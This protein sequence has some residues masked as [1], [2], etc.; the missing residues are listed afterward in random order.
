MDTVE[1]AS[2]LADN[3]D[4]YEPKASS[5]SLK[6]NPQLP[7]VS[8]SPYG[9]HALPSTL[10]QAPDS[11]RQF[12]KQG[13]AGQ[14]RFF[15]TI[16]IAANQSAASSQNQAQSYARWQASGLTLDVIADSPTYAKVPIEQFDAQGNLIVVN[17]QGPWSSTVTYSSGQEVSF[18]GNVWVALSDNTGSTP[19]IGNPFWEL[20]GP[21]TLD[22]VADGAT[23]GRVNNGAL[24]SGGNIDFAG[25]AW[26]NKELDNL[27]DGST[28]AK[29]LGGALTS[30][31]IDFTGSAFL[32]K[33]IDNVSDGVNFARI[34]SHLTW[35]NTSRTPHASAVSVLN[36]D[37]WF[38]FEGNT[39][40]WLFDIGTFPTNLTII[41][42]G[43]YGISQ[44]SLVNGDSLIGGFLTGTG[45]YAF[46]GTHGYSNGSYA[47]SLWAY[48]SGLLPA[49]RS[50][51]FSLANTN[52]STTP[53]VW[54]RGI[55]VDP[56]GMVSAEIA[57]T[58][59]TVAVSSPALN[60]IVPHHIFVNVDGVNLTLWIDGQL[61]GSTTASGT[62][63]NLTWLLLGGHYTGSSWLF[64][65]C[66]LQHV[67][68]W[69]ST[70]L[71]SGQITA[72]Y[73]A[74]S[75][76]AQNL[77][78]LRDGN[79][80][81]RVTGVSGNRT[82]SSSYNTGSISSN[83]TASTGAGSITFAPG[84]PTNIVSLTLS[85]SAQN[86]VL[87]SGLYQCF[88]SSAIGGGT[89]TVNLVVNGTV[90]ASY[91]INTVTLAGGQTFQFTIPAT[92]WAGSLAGATVTL[93]AETTNTTLSTF[94]GAGTNCYLTV[95]N[96]KA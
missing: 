53:T 51:L 87:I 2:L 95:G 62:P 14:Y 68:V 18:G 40:N 46:D 88:W 15:N 60:W 3:L 34:L 21:Q 52:P 39:A 89:V 67:S 41:P 71:T 79:S 32:N 93:Q 82:S 31:N 56:T 83:Y 38:P 75:T 58:G 24:A 43:S 44:S 84:T 29:V 85:A 96:F 54:E 12:Y 36:P 77:D 28:Y 27:P 23:Y 59:G 65:N 11:Q 92:Y 70:A 4:G 47:I 55:Y 64:N 94:T 7:Y 1:R 37:H 50:P 61:V 8:P 20:V 49:S 6:G 5:S 42:A 13:G 81:Q 80:W 76:G 22:N 16:P 69:S 63:F 45:A 74:G 91:V 48:F 10:T 35:N 72:L 9:G 33:N 57:Y 17:F 66:I 90:I 86:A 26:V 78:S 73:Q 30:G 25:A 19:A